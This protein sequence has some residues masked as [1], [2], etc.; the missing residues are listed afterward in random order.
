MRAGFHLLALSF[1]FMFPLVSRGQSVRTETSNTPDGRLHVDFYFDWETSLA[2]FVDS[3]KV[4]SWSEVIVD[5]L[6]GGL[7]NASTTIDLPD[8]AQPSVRVVQRQFDESPVSAAPATAQGGEREAWYAGLGW[9]KKNPVV[10]IA[11]P[12]FVIDREEGVLRRFRHVQVEV[13]PG[14]PEADGTTQL[15]RA[16]KSG[17][18]I[19]SALSTGQLFRL[20]ITES[21]IYRVNR[22]LLTALGLNPD[23][24]DPNSIEIVGNGGRPL[25]ALNAID[26]IQDLRSIP[27]GRS[28]GGDG[29]FGASDEIV[30]Y[31]SGPSGWTYTNGKFEH[32][33]HPY[34]NENAVFIKIGTGSGPELTS[35]PYSPS[36]SMPVFSSTTGRYFLDVEERVWS[37]EHGS[38]TDWMSNTIRSGGSRDFLTGLILPGLQAGTIDYEARV[39]IASNPRATVAMVSGTT[40]LAQRTAPLA[41]TQNSE[42]PSASATTFSFQQSVV[43]GQP[44][45]LTMRLL[46]QTNEPEASFDWVRVTYSQELV[47]GASGPLYFTT[48]P[49]LVGWQAYE[50]SGF[51]EVPKVW[52][53]TDGRY[54]TSYDVGNVSGKYVVQIPANDVLTRPRDLVFFVPSDIINVVASQS[55]P[56]P[57]QNLHGVT[58]F[59][60]MVIV[61]PAAFLPA[62]ERLAAHRRN[63]NLN[64]VV[65]SQAQ[66]FN[67]FAGGVPDMR[68]VRD[69]LRFLYVRAPQN[70][71]PKYLLLMGDGH[72]DF[73]GKSAVTKPLLNLV[74]PYETDE[75]LFTDGTF[76]SDDY[77][78]LLDTNEGVWTY[79]SF[80]QQSSE[81]VDIGIGRFPV[82]TLAEAEMM[83]DKIISYENPSTFG[84]WRTQYTAVADDGPTGL[85]GTQNDNDLHLAN[86]DQV[87]ELVARELYPQINL[88]KI[89]AETYE[90]VFLNGFR[91]PEAKREFSAALN[92]GTL[93]L[94]Y[95]GHGGPDGLAQEEIFTK[96]DALALTNKDKLAIFITATC[97]FGW[98]DLQESQSGAELLLLNPNG[99]AVAMLTTV[100]LVYTSGATDALN[101]GLNR[102]LNIAMFKT[103]IN[104]LPRRLGDILAETKNTSAGLQGNSRKFNLLGDPSMRIGLP[105][106]GAVVSQLN[107]TSLATQTGQMK[108]L[109][110]VNIAGEIQHANGSTNTTFNGS[111]DVTVFDAER[112][113]PLLVRFYNPTS[114]FRQRED[115]LWRGAVQAV[116]GKFNAEFV[117]PKDISY[118]NQSGRIAVYAQAPE[119]QAIGF[120]ENFLVG[121]TSSA[122]PNDQ[123]GPQ[124]RLFLNDSTFVAGQ[125]VDSNPELIVKLFD[126]SGI[127][128]VGTGV[129]HEMLMSLD[130]KDSAAEDIGSG[131]LAET[132]SFQRGVVRW[133][134]SDL[135]PGPHSLSVRAWDVLNNSNTTELAFNVANDEVLDVLNVYNY[136]N[137]MNRETRF[138]FEHNQPQG[139][140]AEV[141]I[142][143]YTLSGRP[144][145]TIH[146]DEAL[147]AGVLGSGPIQVYW[148]GKDDDLDR[149]ATGIYLYRLRVVTHGSNGD[150]QVSEHIEKLAI[151]R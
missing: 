66:V 129:G 77:F 25:P 98:W 38:G 136:P 29:N 46:N 148:D 131:F 3:A 59:P 75:S 18:V 24:I 72:Y 14:V 51:S 82:Q 112:K 108:A 56:V 141:Q 52:D 21:G 125:T 41:T 43:A 147:P 74:F 31:A 104:G 142:R 63:D 135:E 101:A 133:P 13:T 107:Q 68:A 119:F 42:D 65:V 88:H 57:N 62:A 76:T 45:N 116:N 7:L 150:R 36:A 55:S 10:D 27:I 105:S 16:F 139:T 84:S 11:V 54:F 80:T 149:P 128:T 23:T 132:N 123:D 44:I 94:N 28:G 110:L 1:L 91:I 97:S 92:R 79:T 33:V 78:G 100:R 96:E 37:R 111:V 120:T 143:I 34:S 9:L 146:S 102:D 122:P 50:I 145:R 140:S 35:R 89:Y 60:D 95:S 127:N 8:F 61:A 86:V 113:V 124:I 48:R 87:V 114:Y 90:R 17:S 117:V 6:T 93:I 20:S 126:S 85:S 30:F 99:G 109:D 70:Q 67:E 134:L 83:V 4:V 49:G 19:N 130:G 103:D 151:I 58:G 73:R 39:A 144:I 15:D 22:T 32:Y 5:Q 121:G 81:R 137:P 69:Y 64:V 71:L 2:E 118:S 40:T 138:V 26:R 12:V 47:R 106:G 115:L 53:I